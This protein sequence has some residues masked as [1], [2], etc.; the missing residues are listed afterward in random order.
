[1]TLRTIRRSARLAAAGL[2]PALLLQWS[3]QGQIGTLTL[4]DL[5]AIAGAPS[6][7]TVRRVARRAPVIRRQREQVRVAYAK[8][9]DTGREK[10]LQQLAQAL[11]APMIAQQADQQVKVAADKGLLQIPKDRPVTYRHL[12]TVSVQF[13]YEQDKQ[14]RPLAGFEVIPVVQTSGGEEQRLNAVKTNEE[15]RVTLA[16]L[17]KVPARFEFRLSKT[18]EKNALTEWRYREPEKSSLA[19]T[20]FTGEPKVAG[21]APLRPPGIRI[22]S[23]SLRGL[24]AG[25][26]TGFQRKAA[27]RTAPKPAPAASLK[28]REEAVQLAQKAAGRIADA[29][30]ILKNRP[31]TE[32]P[33][34]TAKLAGDFLTEAFN[35]AIQARTRDASLLRAHQYAA[36]ALWL[37]G[38]QDRAVKVLETVPATAMKSPAER[39]ERDTQLASYR[40]A[41][42]QKPAPMPPPKEPEK[43]AEPVVVTVQHVHEAPPLVVERTVVDM[44]LKLPEGADQA[45]ISIPRVNPDTPMA[46]G[47][48]E[49]EIQAEREGG[50]AKFRLATDMFAHGPLPIH[51]TKSTPS[52]EWE[53]VVDGYPTPDPYNPM[54]LTAPPLRLVS[55][56][57]AQ[58]PKGVDVL[59]LANDAE[60]V[61]PGLVERGKKSRD[62]DKKNTPSDA[63]DNGDGSRWEK[64]TANTVEMRIRPVPMGRRDRDG[65]SE[66][67]ELVEA[68]RLIGQGMGPVGGIR[69]GDDG[70]SVEKVLGPPEQ[71]GADGLS[72]LQGGVKYFVRLGRVQHIELTRPVRLLR[73]G[74]TAFTPRRPA[75]LFVENFRAPEGRQIRDKRDL[76]QYLARTGVVQVVD[77]KEEADYVLDAQLQ[78][79]REKKDNLLGTVP[80][81]YECGADLTYSLFDQ[82]DNKWVEQRVRL[83]AQRKANWSADFAKV[84]LPAAIIGRVVGGVGGAALGTAIGAAGIVKL[85]ESMGRAVDRTPKLVE[86]A[87]YNQLSDRLYKEVDFSGRVT[88]IDYKTGEVTINLGTAEGVRPG[89]LAQD[90]SSF[91]LLVG[92][93]GLTSEEEGLK[94]DFYTLQVV[95]AEEHQS[96]CVLKHVRRTL[97]GKGTREEIKVEDDPAMV[98]GIPHPATGLVSAQMRNRLITLN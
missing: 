31:I 49:E 97:V 24:L 42:A 39:R 58:A 87:I 11:P 23:T 89:S 83:S 85:R 12:Q 76:A 4:A 63:V 5:D 22:A 61:F 26:L 14:P 20:G 90:A 3:A 53:T 93:K 66:Q 7:P 36:R 51:L 47:A 62:K 91:D 52:G 45:K 60:R 38:E 54:E 71:S 46:A 98:K 70:N 95:S 74:T 80:L 50:T 40:T 67:V 48:V 41:L 9:L 96:R 59:S 68:I 25:V 43:P 6:K 73:E 34:E 10:A 77:S 79:F 8:N 44:T 17:E 55:L 75:K 78:D 16:N 37:R 86:Q 81:E 92:G 28:Q 33:E 30:K 69:V 72:Y 13:Q 82:V 35:L 19:L 56:S 57:D 88:A 29:E 2:A 15:G 64:D 27:P 94:A 65:R 84:A 18:A 32:L 21:I 1:M